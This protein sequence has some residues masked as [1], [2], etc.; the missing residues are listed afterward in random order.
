[1]CLVI[2]MGGEWEQHII[3]YFKTTITETPAKYPA[4]NILF[5]E[6]HK[7]ATMDNNQP[8]GKRVRADRSTQES[9]GE[10]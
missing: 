1:M 4:T 3:A 7:Q 2:V 8:A 9:G 6:C 5:R 10:L